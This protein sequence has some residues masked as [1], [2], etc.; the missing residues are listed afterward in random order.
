MFCR[1][2]DMIMNPS[3]NDV[4]MGFFIKILDNGILNWF[5]IERHFCYG[6]VRAHASNYWMFLHPIVGCKSNSWS[7]SGS[8]ILSETDILMQ[9]Y[10][11]RWSKIIV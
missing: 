6:T 5:T 4:L 2:T 3:Q 9:L 1:D 11:I 10:Q 8:W 7:K